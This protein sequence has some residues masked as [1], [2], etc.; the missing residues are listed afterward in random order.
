MAPPGRSRRCASA[1][2]RSGSGVAED[3]VQDD[4]I[5]AGVVERYLTCDLPEHGGRSFA[6]LVCSKAEE[7]RGR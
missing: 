7:F 4:G 1:S 6:K 3:G 5:G 2:S